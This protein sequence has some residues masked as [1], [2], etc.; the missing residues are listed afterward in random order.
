MVGEITDPASTPLGI[1]ILVRT[2]YGKAA[3]R[4]V[5]I[6][7][8]P[9][10][11][12]M[13]GLFRRSNKALDP[14]SKEESAESI[15]K[16][17][18][19]I[20]HQAVYPK[21]S[22]GDQHDKTATSLL[23]ELKGLWK[24]A[25]EELYEEDARLIKA[26]EHALLQQD[27]L[28]SQGS[29]AGTDNPTDLRSLVERRFKE[30]ESSRL[31]ITFAGR[32][33]TV[34]EQARR[35]IDLIISLKPSIAIAVGADPHAAL[36]WAGIMLLLAPISRTLTQDGIAMEGFEYILKIL[37]QYRVLE[38]THV[39]VYLKEST[40]ESKNVK[41]LDELGASI[42]SQSVKLYVTVLRYQMRLAQ[43]FAQSG[44]LRFFADLK[45]T[46]DWNKMLQDIKKIDDSINRQLNTLSSNNL[47]Q[48][49]TEIKRLHDEM[50]ES[51]YVMREV[52]DETKVRQTL[53][54][55][56]SA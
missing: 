2:S 18:G 4:E 31:K 15:S 39:E 51:R 3:G 25:Y 33:I 23:L 20:S 28:E 47:R 16:S 45:M 49:Q 13:K 36:A 11:N 21:Q 53:N 43:H 38:S 10:R 7:S 41:P 46:D 44:L 8:M 14:P 5:S 56:L 12:G 19:S 50:V 24:E 48:I 9:L 29:S 27:D 32:E 17:E 40:P 26:Y 55:S 34:R 37:V 35:A 54:H 1:N 30:I 22:I 6:S 52:I 42:R